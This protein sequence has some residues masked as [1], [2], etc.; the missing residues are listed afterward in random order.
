[1]NK[2][3]G[4]LLLSGLMI[5]P[6]LG[7]GI[8]LLPPMAYEKLGNASLWAWIIIMALGAIFAMIF[9]KLTILHPGDGGMTIAIEKAMGHKLKLYAS[10]LMISA[11]SFGPSAVML[12][13]AEYLAKLKVLESVPE[14]VLALLLVGLCLILLLKDIK[15]ISTLSFALSTAISAVLA[16]SSV[17]VLTGASINIRPISQVNTTSLG[18]V[19][20]LLFWAIIGWEIIG[21]YSEQVR[22]LKRTVPRATLLSL[23]II[24]GTYLIISLAVQS[25]PRTGD[26]SLIHVLQPTFGSLS[27]GILA[28]LVT[29]LCVCTYLLIVGALGRLVHSLAVESHFPAVLSKVNHSGVPVAAISYF[30]CAHAFVLTASLTGILDIE[31][32]VSIANGFFL[33]NALIGLIA[34]IKII[35]SPLYRAGAIILSVSLLFILSFSSAKIYIALATVYLLA[36]YL[37]KRHEKR[38]TGKVVHQQ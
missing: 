13:A 31:G 5:G 17:V 14:A 12:T 1:M 32:I 19:V 7:S 16:V 36:H 24:T 38:V 37:D 21:N 30:I 23:V 25:L 6:I 22:D 27:V 26:L 4:P 18:Q 11:V 2:K 35:R 9:S 3:I 15:F 8:I 34:A 29:G 33:A 20:L 28:L 10:L